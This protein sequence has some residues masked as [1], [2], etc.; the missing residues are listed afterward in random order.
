M[1]IHSGIR[2][3]KALLAL[4][5]LAGIGV[6]LAAACSGPGSQDK[7]AT[8]PSADAP[9]KTAAALPSNPLKNAYFGEPHVHTAYSLDAYIGGARLTPSDAY[10][11]AKGEEVEV[12]GTKVRMAAL[13]WAAVT[14]HAEYIGEMYSTLNPGAPGYDNEQIKQLRALKGL[15]ERENWFMEYVLKPNRGTPAHPPFFAGF[16]TTVSG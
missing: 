7:V 13:D 10:R 6:L 14:D 16:E 1:K 12:G 4:P 8:A 2:A 9:A 3:G 11:F 5:V 15:D